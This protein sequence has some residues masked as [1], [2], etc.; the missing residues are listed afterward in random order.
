MRELLRRWSELRSKKNEDDLV[1]LV[2]QDSQSVE[3]RLNRLQPTEREEARKI[4][5]ELASI[6]SVTNE[7]DRARDL[8]DMVLRAFEDT[9]FFSLLR[10]LSKA[11][12]TE[13]EEVL[14]LVTELDVFETIKMAEVVRAR[15]GVIGNFRGLIETDVPE[16]PDMQEFLFHHPWL[17]NPEWQVVEHE[18]S[19]ERLVV[20]QFKLDPAERDPDSHRRVDFFC[21]G[22]R[23]RYLV[24]EVKR[25]SKSIGKGEVQQL[26]DY[27]LFLREQAPGEPKAPNQYEGVLVGHHLTAEGV[28]WKMT[29]PKMESPFEAG[30]SF[31][32]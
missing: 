12:R 26:V 11:D 9:A 17:I 1:A 19:L 21:V 20:E 3:A 15:V 13:R 6:E 23:G 18:K 27:V 7:P 10:A 8:L 28:R 22:T 2:T 16:K 30:R 31:S 5:R 14:R 29:R 32:E 24:V 25:P 4:I